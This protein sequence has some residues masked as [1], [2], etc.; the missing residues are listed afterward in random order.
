MSFYL[1]LE[2]KIF[3]DIDILDHTCQAA[4]RMKIT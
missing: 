1:V 4:K 2:S 3:G